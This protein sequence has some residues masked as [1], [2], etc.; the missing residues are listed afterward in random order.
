MRLAYAIKSEDMNKL[1]IDSKLQLKKEVV[2]S[3]NDDE[4]DDVLGG[5]KT[6]TDVLSKILTWTNRNTILGPSC[7]RICNPDGFT[8]M[9]HTRRGCAQ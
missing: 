3:L 1:K 8:T 6:T 5:A 7:D 2:A 4:M 9:R